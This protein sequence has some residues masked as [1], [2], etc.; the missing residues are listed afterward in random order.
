MIQIENLVVSLG[1]RVILDNVNLDIPEGQCLAI[2]GPSGLGK[3]TLLKTIVG[4]H[5]ASAGRIS[6]LGAVGYCQQNAPLFPWLSVIGNLELASSLPRSEIE[7]LLA[8]VGLAGIEEMKPH[9]I[10]AG[11]RRRVTVL[12]AF[13][14]TGTTVLLD[15]P[16]AGL[17][18]V[19][20]DQLIALVTELWRHSGKTLIYVTHDIDEALRIA[21]RIIVFGARCQELTLDIANL[22]PTPRQISTADSSSLLTYQRLWGEIE[23]AIKASHLQ[24]H[25]G[26]SQSI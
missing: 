23:H 10:S 7:K 22:L 24:T 3:S 17:D 2:M 12:R 25:H 16:F 19:T 11:M 20:R 21:D 9:A 5:A 18:I 6:G 26:K 13:L 14:N 8:Q 1:G 15:E 4:E